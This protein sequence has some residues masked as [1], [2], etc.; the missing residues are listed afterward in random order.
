MGLL[1]WRHS[2]HSL[3]LERSTENQPTASSSGALG[4]GAHACHVGFRVL[5]K[6]LLGSWIGSG[7]TQRVCSLFGGKVWVGGGADAGQAALVWAQE[8]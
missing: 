3:I 7:R 2:S 4:V 8:L 1:Q 5:A 6:V